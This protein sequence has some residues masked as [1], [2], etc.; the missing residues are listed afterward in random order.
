MIVSKQDEISNT[1]IKQEPVND[2]NNKEYDEYLDDDSETERT[3]E[4]RTK[5]SKSTKKPRA[6]TTRAQF[7]KLIA[8]M[9]CHSDFNKGKPPNKETAETLRI[10]DAWNILIAEL[11]A[12]GP[13]IRTSPEWR[14]AWTN[15]KSNKRRRQAANEANG[16]P[17][18]GVKRMRFETCTLSGNLTTDLTP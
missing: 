2:I 15:F 14:R 7:Q 12:I 6:K 16:E 9:R 5:N 11:N 17:S 4:N 13:P 8:F 18:E 1:G 3:E 10:D